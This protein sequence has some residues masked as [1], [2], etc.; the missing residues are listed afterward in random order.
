MDSASAP[1]LGTIVEVPQGRGVIRFSG[2]TSFST[3]KWIGIELYQPNGK[4]DGS[5]NGI[6][7]FSCKP[8]FGVFVRPSL[9]KATFGSELDNVRP[10]F[11]F[12]RVM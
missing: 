4:N 1:S 5:V 8:N 9:I 7:Y 10:P 6:T 12:L 2:A 3:G 11:A